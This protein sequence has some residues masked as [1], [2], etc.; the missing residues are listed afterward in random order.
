M[1]LRRI[2]RLHTRAA[3]PGVRGAFFNAALPRA[4]DRADVAH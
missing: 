2:R 1:T 4:R 3:C